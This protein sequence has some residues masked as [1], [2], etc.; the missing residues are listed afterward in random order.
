M[1]IKKQAKDRIQHLEKVHGYLTPE[2]VVDD[3]MDPDSPLHGEFTWDKNLAARAHWLHTARQLIRS[4]KIIVITDSKT[5]STVAYVRDPNKSGHEQ[6]YLSVENIRN[7]KEMARD[8]LID[9]FKRA[10]AAMQRA[11]RL[12]IVFD[13]ENEVDIMAK[14]IN[15]LRKNVE[16]YSLNS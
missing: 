7:D 3:A 11:Q 13:I 12:A 15:K 1:D 14:R 9:E 8:V 4:V 5:V 16:E 2:M 10:G 6:G